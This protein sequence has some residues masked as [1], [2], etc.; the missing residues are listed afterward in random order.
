MR[1]TEKE[2]GP[3]WLKRDASISPFKA[4]AAVAEPCMGT[5]MAAKM[6]QNTCNPD[7]SWGVTTGKS[8]M[9][10]NSWPA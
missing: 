8:V 9:D 4:P 10:D 6:S 3:R 7:R 5:I 1:D 2:K